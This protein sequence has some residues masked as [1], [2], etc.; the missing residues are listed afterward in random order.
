MA[1][2]PPTPDPEGNARNEP[3]HDDEIS[4]VDLYLTLL[5]RWKVLVGTFVLVVVAVGGYAAHHHASIEPVYEATGAVSVGTLARQPVVNPAV[6]AE[7]I[8][9]RLEDA[10]RMDAAE[11]PYVAG[12]RG[13]D[14]A[15]LVRVRSDR[16][17]GLTEYLEERLAEIEPWVVGRSERALPEF[18]ERQ[19]RRG[20]RFAAMAERIERLE[21]AIDQ[22]TE[23]VTRGVPEGDGGPIDPATVLVQERL[24]ERL[25]KL[26]EAYA[27]RQEEEPE[28]DAD[29]GYRVAAI[30]G[31]TRGPSAQH[32]S[33]A[34]LILALG[35]V[36]GAMLSVFAA[37]FAEFLAT[38][39]QSW[40][41][42][43]GRGEA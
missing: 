12:V 3:R 35:V 23:R 2:Q 21:A 17:E 20:A 16:P 11:R 18:R 7:R 31:V 38:A 24:F 1:S 8:A 39:H 34:P 27:K 10:G 22:I 42:R 40:R 19:E 9:W 15:V 5:R 28:A 33:R 32:D 30:Q 25:E 41:E 14:D 4:L 29:A 37:F 43:R 13:N 26:E 6:L 36:L